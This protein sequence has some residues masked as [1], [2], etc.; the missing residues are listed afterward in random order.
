MT[1]NPLSAPLT[2]TSLMNVAEVATLI[3]AENMAE[4]VTDNVFE[5][6]TPL[7]T[8]SPADSTTSLAN[9]PLPPEPALTPTPAGN[10][11]NIFMRLSPYGCGCPCAAIHTIVAEPPVVVT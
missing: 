2:L 3:P 7:V 4:P 10:N 6:R 1:L 11:S 8:K 5:K 9:V